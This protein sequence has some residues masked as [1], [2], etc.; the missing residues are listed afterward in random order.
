MQTIDI[1]VEPT[2]HPRARKLILD[3]DV[4]TGNGIS[5][6]DAATCKH[7]PMAVALLGVA[8]VSDV[9]FAG[10]VITVTTARGTDWSVVDGPVRALV[11]EHLTAHDPAMTPPAE[12][13]RAT[14]G[15]TAVIDG[16]LEQTIRP[17]IRSHGGE[18]EVL[19]Y[20]PVSKRLLVTYQGTCGHCPAST[21]GTLQVI[22]QILREEFD[23]EIHL[24]IV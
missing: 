22:Q 23:P 15:N 12:L 21:S 9:H 20:D 7:V 3:R 2:A 13:V 1:I 17:Y 11:A 8:G 14:V 19:E 5:F 4:R 6:A 10:N 24:E 18:V 16:I